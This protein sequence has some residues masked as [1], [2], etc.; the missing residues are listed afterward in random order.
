MLTKIFGPPGSGK[1]TYL[2]DTVKQELERGTHSTDIGYFA[3]TRK[4]AHEARDRAI[5]K[6]P[7]LSA[8]LDFPW[9]RTLHSLAYS[10]L[11]VGNKDIMSSA[12]Y[13]EF[14]KSVGLEVSTSTDGNDFVIRADNA[15]LNE[16]NIARIRGEDLHSYYNRS[17]LEIE[18]FH[19]EY[20]ERSYRKF[21]ESKM[22][23]DFTDLLELLVQDPERLPTLQALI[24]DEA[25]DL[26]KLQWT[27]VMQLAERA[28]RTW[29]AGDDDQAV[30]IWAGADVE[31]F[32][33]CE[34]EIRV[35]NQSYRVPS[36]IHS[37]ADKIV[38]RIK[39]RQPKEWTPRTEGG[40]INYYNDFQQVDIS[41]GQWLVMASTN[42][43]L[44]DMHDWMKSQ[45]LLFERHG[46][47]SVS[48]AV[49]TAVVG[50]ERLRGG[51]SINYSVLKQVYKHLG[52]GTVKR[53]YRTL[54]DADPEDM[55]SMDSLKENHGLQTEAIWHE[56]LG[57]IGEDKRDYLVAVLRRGT[58][59]SAKAPIQLSTIHGAKGGEADNVLLLTDLSP[60]FAK[61]YE[62]NADSINRLLYVGV[63]RTR[64]ALHIVLPKKAERG[65]R[66]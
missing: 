15:I 24:I 57:K 19:F 16:I 48:E 61:E 55:F 59:L 34:G 5:E 35:L 13:T 21:K 36:K 22:L 9:F 38:R 2:L 62:Y 29:I 10:C 53:G 1:T 27:L 4:A 7:H 43:M 30:Y 12:D 31:S 50:W 33:S 65:F 37:F 66:F 52:A 54:K 47:K 17:N 32:L 39:R 44:N 18:W 56:A 40:E 46:H 28:Q 60:R 41:S 63:T 51:Q 20:I 64:Q 26:S 8:D 14:A 23:M 6:F 45:G 42:Y 25:Q 49:L 3:F 11:G 58:K